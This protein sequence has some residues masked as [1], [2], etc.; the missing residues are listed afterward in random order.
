MSRGSRYEF[1]DVAWTAT[2]VD[3]MHQDA[4]P[5]DVAWT[6][7]DVDHMHQNAQPV[8]EWNEFDK[9]MNN[10]YGLETEFYSLFLIID[11]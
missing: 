7:T 10:E 5:V 9:I 2:D 1:G 8:A 11:K 6:A 3:H 4:Q